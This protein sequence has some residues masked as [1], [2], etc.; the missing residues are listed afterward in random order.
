MSVKLYKHN[1]ETYENIKKA[2]L[3][4]NRVGIVQPTGTGK[5]FIFLKWIEDNKQD[6]FV[7]LSPSVEIFT[8]LKGYAI[9]SV[10]SDLFINCEMI[11]FQRLLY[12]SDEEIKSIYAD[13]IIIDE[14]H[15]V[16][17][18]L[19]SIKV[20]KL[21]NSNPKALV[22]GATATPVRYLDGGRNMSEELFDNRLAR[23]MTLGEAVV[24]GILPTPIYVP[25]W[26]EQDT[27]VE[28]LQ[29]DIDSISDET[30]RKE[31]N[32]K[33]KVLRERLIYSYG[34][35]DIFKKN[36]PTNHGKY[37]VFCSDNEHLQEMKSKMSLW[38]NG[39]VN[40][41]NFYTSVSQFADR[42]EQLS[43]FKED[44]SNDAIK[45]LF[46]IDRLNEGVHIKG[47]DGV[48][49]LRPTI[50]PIIYLQQMGRA[51]A[52]GNKRP[53][54]FDLVN[55]FQNVQIFADGSEGV[56]IFVNEFSEAFEEY[57]LE[58]ADTTIYKVFE[59]VIEFN[60]LFYSL[61]NLLYVD[62]ERKWQQT[63][64]IVKDYIIEH[65]E[66]PAATTVY[67]NVHIGSWLRY[68]NRSYTRGTLLMHR[69]NLLRQAGITLGQRNELIWNNYYTLLQDYIKEHS[70]MPGDRVVYNG[71]K[72]GKWLAN[73]KRK[74]NE[75]NLSEER[76]E[77]LQSAG[78]IFDNIL[79]KRWLETFNI[80]AEYVK[81][82]GVEPKNNT[83]YKGVKIGLWLRRQQNIYKTGRLQDYRQKKLES[84]GIKMSSK[85]DKLWENNYAVL[86]EYI[87][88][89]GKI[90]VISTVYKDTNIGTWLRYQKDSMRK[91][92][93]PAERRKKLEELRV[94]LFGK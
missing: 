35:A 83:E 79:D 54:I 82:T 62:N 19:W 76:L 28:K 91:G 75:N 40:K 5:S 90:P 9:E 44:N 49:M 4:E 14:F 25:V 88:T 34:A 41:I 64:E 16:G 39:F 36:M 21:L 92:T 69:E 45:L 7:I 1:K 71:Y 33:L 94:D 93:L 42:D 18:D 8:Q 52:S 58:S 6:K 47:I 2:F 30:K 85:N 70:D 67:K 81:E 23:Y 11:T 37:I 32:E 84:L 13:K 29:K 3:T 72:I 15:R 78:V 22:L 89:S 77:M 12:M 38:L 74:Y 87:S 10:A 55:N 53:I 86:V 46:T 20:E 60:N 51:L 66:E 48:I 31:L 50:S 26:Y 27:R 63:Y 73:Q 65:K 56:N 17:A 57:M 24:K 61:E 68:Q 43:K 59:R 80:V